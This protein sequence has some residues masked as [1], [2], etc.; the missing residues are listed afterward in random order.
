[1]S[2]VDA[3][4]GSSTGTR[5]PR[6]WVLL[7]APRFEGVNHANDHDSRSRHRQICFSGPGVDAQ[8]KVVVRRQ[9]KRRHVL[10]FFQKLPVCLIGIE[11]CASARY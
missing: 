9:L 8:G 11:A 2:A 10:A 7:E 1:M 3:V 4:D 6:M 5:V